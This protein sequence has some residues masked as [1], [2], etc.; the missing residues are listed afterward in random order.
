MLAT[1]EHQRDTWVTHLKMLLATGILWF[2]AF[3]QIYWNGPMGLFEDVSSDHVWVNVGLPIL[4]TVLSFVICFAVLKYS[5][6]PYLHKD[7]QVHA[8][9]L[10]GA[11]AALKVLVIA[12]T[13]KIWET[14][15]DWQILSVVSWIIAIAICSVWIFCDARRANLPRLVILA[16]LAWAAWLAHGQFVSRTS[17]MDIFV[18][19]PPPTQLESFY[20][21]LEP[22]AYSGRLVM[23]TALIGF[24]VGLLCAHPNTRGQGFETMP[25]PPFSVGT[26]LRRQFLGE[27]YSKANWS[28]GILFSIILASSFLAMHAIVFQG[29]QIWPFRIVDLQSTIARVFAENAVH[30][31]PTA[32]WSIAP[33]VI[34]GMALTLILNHFRLTGPAPIIACGALLGLLWSQTVSG[35]YRLMFLDLH[36]TAVL[37]GMIIAAGFGVAANLLGK[38]NDNTHPA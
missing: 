7:T 5:F 17:F 27:K 11:E 16:G 34:A 29:F 2:F 38:S 10:R 3:Q 26:W 9:G 32:L 19:T 20:R 36:V 25:F 28:V 23:E 24:S 15:T 1:T 14:T 13:V 22:L 37:G 4:V 6:R 21:A 30:H 31:L 18:R 8:A 33:F 12:L 35:L